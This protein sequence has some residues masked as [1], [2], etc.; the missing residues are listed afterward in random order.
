MLKLSLIYVCFTLDWR[1]GL[2]SIFAFY[3]R[4]LFKYDYCEVGQM[5]LIF[6][7]IGTG[8]STLL[9]RIAHMEQKRIEKER[10]PFK[11]IVS[12]VHIKGCLYV[13]NIR[14]LL[15]KGMF[16]NAL[17]LSD[18][19]GVSYSNRAMNMTAQ[20]IEE[21]KLLRHYDCTFLFISQ[22]HEDLDVVLRRLYTKISLLRSYGD[23]TII[24]DIGKT[25]DINEEGKIDDRYHFYS[26]LLF[27]KAF[28]KPAYYH[29]FDSYYKPA[30][31][32]VID[33]ENRTVTCKGFITHIIS[34]DEL[35][36]I[37]S[38]KDMT[39]REKLECNRN[40]K[41]LFETGLYTIE[42]GKLILSKRSKKSPEAES[43][44]DNDV[45]ED[46]GRCEEVS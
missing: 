23:Y 12:D 10:S 1:I 21:A 45:K 46:T 43:V 32:P 33:I 2:F 7:P 44:G 17:L 11:Y 16:K 19:A 5:H 42:K 22:N 15:K 37:Q 26:F 13:P 25:I 4:R 35:T 38:A 9:A 8:K 29:M 41:T 40:I 20:E 31:I 36:Q 14:D 39:L 24:K 27:N 34:Q 3:L 18:E 28:Y 30:H 6:A